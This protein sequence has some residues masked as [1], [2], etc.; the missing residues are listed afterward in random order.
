MGNRPL[1]DGNFGDDVLF[2]DVNPNR[3]VTLGWQS[4]LI[5]DGATVETNNE[6][7]VLNYYEK[8][9]RAKNCVHVPFGPAPILATVTSRKVKKGQELFTTYGCT[10]WLDALLGVDEESTDIT[11]AIQSEVKEAARDIF[12]SMQIVAVTDVNEAGR[13]RS[14]FDMK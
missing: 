7:G 6:S 12:T 3:P 9:R 4:H 10:Y 14:T 1:L 8:S 5:N 13:L 2:V 11:Q